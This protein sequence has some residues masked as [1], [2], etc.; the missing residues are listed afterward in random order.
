MNYQSLDPSKYQTRF[1]QALATPSKEQPLK[2]SIVTDSL[3]NP[4]RYYA[5]SYCWGDIT[6]QTLITVDGEPV[7]VSRNLEAALRHS[8]LRPG[9][10]IWADAIC[11][12]QNDLDEKTRQVMLMDRVY[13]KAAETIVW[14]GEETPNSRH[15]HTLLDEMKKDVRQDSISS[16]D[17]DLALRHTANPVRALRGL[18][19]LF[20]SPYWE[21]VWIIQ[22]IAKSQSVSVRCGSLWFDLGSFFACYGHLKDLPKRSHTLIFAIQHFREQESTAL[23]DGKRMPLLKALIRSCHFL[24]TQP[25]DKVYAL[26]GLTRD[27]RDLVP[28]PTYTSPDQLIFGELSKRLLESPLR[29]DV[30]L[31]SL[32]APLGAKLESMPSCLVDWAD[33]GFNVPPWL[34]TNLWDRYRNLEQWNYG[35]GNLVS[36]SESVKLPTRG[37]SL[38]TIFSIGDGPPTNTVHMPSMWRNTSPKIMDSVSSKLLRQFLPNR[39]DLHAMSKTELA[40]ALAH[41][42]TG[43]IDGGVSRHLSKGTYTGEVRR[44]LQRLRI[45]NF[46]IKDFASACLAL[47]MSPNGD[48]KELD[49]HESTGKKVTKG[50]TKSTKKESKKKGD[51][52]YDTSSQVSNDSIAYSPPSLAAYRVWDDVFSALYLYPEYGLRLASVGYKANEYDPRY[53][54]THVIMIPRGAQVGDALYQLESCYF[55]AVLRRRSNGECTV[56]GEACIGKDSRDHWIPHHS[57]LWLSKIR[58]DKEQLVLIV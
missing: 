30:I 53:K 22:E 1:L 57:C 10:L 8:V 2:F 18:Y 31:L 45:G 44:Q 58:T 41:I 13:L 54:T 34:T 27:G 48:H 19:E 17:F 39:P 55:P 15:A 14:L 28:I 36:S 46:S 50:S 29:M 6:N 3:D 11:I 38:G 24:A 9:D 37:K 4:P 49:E 21:R 42:M 23:K 25:R 26:L 20:A 56:L 32:W 40:M 16:E 33:L 12:N 5:L 52:G 7:S 35:F 47:T 51:V 43:T